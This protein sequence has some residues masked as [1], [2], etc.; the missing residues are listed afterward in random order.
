M[1]SSCL[2]RNVHHGEAKISPIACA[3]R[4]CQLMLLFS[5]PSVCWSLGRSPSAGQERPV[6]GRRRGLLGTRTTLLSFCWV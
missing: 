5:A 2:H 4:S 1:L 3:Q 6:A